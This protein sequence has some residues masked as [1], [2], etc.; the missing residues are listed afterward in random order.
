MHTIVSGYVE[1]GEVPGLVGLVWRRGDIHLEVI[2][3]MSVGGQPVKRDSIFRI[4]SMTTGLASVGSYGWTG[5]LGS[6]WESDPREEMVTIL[7]TSKL[8]ESPSPPPV[9]ADFWTQAYA[10]IDD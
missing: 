1:R 10:A 3:T 8:W 2:G 4:A 5:G 6:M 7:L 9:F